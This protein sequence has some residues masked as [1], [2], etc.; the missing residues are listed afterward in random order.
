MK[1]AA[2]IIAI[3]FMAV[4]TGII[5][6]YER[7][8]ADVRKIVLIAVMTAITVAGRLIFAPFPGFKPVTALVVITGIYLG[9]EAGFYCGILTPLITNFY[10]GQGPYTPFQMLIWGGIGICAAM[11]AGILKKNMVILSIFGV[12]SGIVFSLFMDI[13]SVIW[14]VGSW[15]WKVYLTMIGTSAPFT[16]IYA[17]SNVIF[18]LLFKTLAGKKLERIS[19]KYYVNIKNF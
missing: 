10:F 9:K 8:D 17:V 4:L 13:Y 2:L 12:L 14:A 16:T 18:L 19:K 3:L 7:K 5:T 11:M 15:N 1:T 6:I